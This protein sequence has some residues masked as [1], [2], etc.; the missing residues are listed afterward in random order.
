[1][2]NEVEGIVVEISADARQFTA[3]LN[4][5]ANQS[6]DFGRRAASAAKIGLAAFATAAAAAAT[7]IA[8]L[9]AKGIENVSRLNDIATAAGVAVED[10]QALEAAFGLA[11][12]SSDQTKNAL[13]KLNETIGE[14]RSGNSAAAASFAALGLNIEELQKLPA[15]ERMAQIADAIAGVGDSAD[16]AKAA[17]DIFGKSGMDMLAAFADGGQGIRDTKKELKD[18]GIT[19]STIDAAK[20]DAAGDSLDRMG[21]I[22][23][24]ISNR[25]AVELSPAISTFVD[26]L[27]DSAKESGGFGDGIKTASDI[28]VKAIAFVMNIFSGLKRTVEIITVGIASAFIETWLSIKSK[29]YEM[30]IS[31]SEYLN[32]IPGVNIDTSGL[33]KSNDEMLAQLQASRD[34]FGQVFLEPLAGDV[35]LEKV[36]ARKAA[37]ESAAQAAIDAEKKKSEAIKKI[38]TGGAGGEQEDPEKLKDAAFKKIEEQ[39]QREIEMEKTKA[40]ALKAFNDDQYNLQNA[41]DEQRRAA[42]LARIQQHEAQRKAI[43]DTAYAN[44]QIS[45]EQH[46]AR[47]TQIEQDGNAARK[48]LTDLEREQKLSATSSM[49]SGLAALA[50]TGGKK[51]FDIGKAFA[52]SSSII[53]SYGAFSKAL[54]SNIPFPFNIAAAAGVLAQG[55]ANVQRIRSTS[56]GSTSAS[57]GGSGGGGVQSGTATQSASPAA[58]NSPRQVNNISIVGDTFGRG[59]LI[60]LAERMSK[61][62]KD[63]IEYRF[64]GA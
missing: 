25:F 14:A 40:A 46:Q 33:K 35:Y 59:Q 64:S 42:E 23:S 51:M 2:A 60:D 41:T 12:I 37:D 56:Y 44:D 29:A 3:T 57:G 62:V 1:M 10:Y 18:L 21:G 43:A 22:V 32:K 34:S 6:D 36:A 20:V 47:I 15:D 9:T 5:A 24:G 16:Q 11:G 49:F 27:I 7:A 31:I 58:Q 55:L 4:D 63:G 54:N 13:L 38:K 45:E 19:I 30:V 61:G 8:G 53:D 50:Q 26:M 52:I 28:A 17:T 48:A 39:M